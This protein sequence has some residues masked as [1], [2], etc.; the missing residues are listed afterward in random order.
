MKTQRKP[1][2]VEVKRGT[3]RSAFISPSQEPDVFRKAEALLFRVEQPDAPASNNAP[4]SGTNPSRRILQAI[5]EPQG[6][7]LPT[8]YE[9]PGPRGRKPGSKNKPKLTDVVGGEEASTPLGSDNE[10]P[11]RRGRPPASKGWVRPID[12]PENARW[13]TLTSAE[14]Q[15]HVSVGNGAS[16]PSNPVLRVKRRGR[17]LG[18]KNKPKLSGTGPSIPAKIV[19]ALKPAGVDVEADDVSVSHQGRELGHVD[20]E[21]PDVRSPRSTDD[22]RSSRPGTRLRDRSKILRRYVLRTEPKAG[23][24]GHRRRRS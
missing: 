9:A 15:E 18:S 8:S 19:T 22:S 11:R 2:Q 7:L 6:P 10:T 16:T 13:P 12:L 20:Q 21:A 3:S 14:A 17:P 4:V 23:D 5:E 24:R 1:F